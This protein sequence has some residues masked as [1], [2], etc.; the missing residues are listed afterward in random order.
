M[1]HVAVGG[2]G[3]VR[4]H[5][6][7]GGRF[8]E[9]RLGFEE[10]ES[11]SADRMRAWQEERLRRL[12][13]IAW[14]APS[15]RLRFSAAGVTPP[16]ERF[17]IDDLS[18]LPV[19]TKD[20]VRRDP[21]GLCPGGASGRRVGAYYTSGSSGT[22]LTVYY[23]NDDFRRS[24][25]LRSAR[26][27]SFAGVDYTTPRATFS[28]RQVAP[29]ADAS[30]PFHR[31][32]AV[33][34]QVYL[35]P[36]HLGPATVETYVEAFQTHRP[37]W[38]TGYAGSIALLARL[39][40]EQG[41]EFPPLL[42]VITAAEPVPPSLRV[43]GPHAFGCRVTEEYGLMEQTAFALECEHGSLHLSPDAAFVEVL[44]EDDNPCPPGTVGEIVGTSFLREAQPL[45]R[46]RT[47]DLGTLS[48]DGCL[49]GRHWPVLASVEGRVDDVIVT[50][51]GHR[52]GRLSTVP[53]HLPGLVACQFVQ[54]RRDLIAVHVVCEGTL[55]AEV[56]ETLR[57][58]LQERLG[59]A[60]DVRVEQV[61]PDAL[62]LTPRGKVR[63]IV[64]RI[65][66]DG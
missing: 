18:Q 28:G 64:S 51:A 34:R 1:Q 38:L 24:F 25:A 44:D 42:A 10:R 6:R 15:Y 31:Y 7:L 43:D 39:A 22:P 20:E 29:D 5:R 13:A 47:G 36:Y 56:A 11:W 16:F 61:A 65:D 58:R 33:E 45:I 21:D 8:P 14:T 2:Y 46:Y 35:S 62:E 40:L 59:E 3:L 41:L 30:G 4:R 9:Y 17:S 53:K 66:T 48:P 49:C 32:N 57:A 23:S 12:L 52:V 50:P 37:L 63:G 27:R 54:E 60:M 26:Y 55:A 19:L